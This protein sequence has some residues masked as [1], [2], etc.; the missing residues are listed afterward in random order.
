V[1][2]AGSETSMIQ[3]I[4]SLWNSLVFKIIL[5]V[6]AI[7]LIVITAWAF[8]NIHH[9]KKM[10]MDDIVR[11]C[12]QLSRAIRLGTHYAMMFNARE[13]INQII[14]NIGKLEGLEHIRI[15]DKTG[16]IKFSNIPSEV[17]VTTGIK[18]E[19]CDICH[20]VDPPLSSLPLENRKRIFVTENH[21][22]AIGMISPILNEQGCATSDCHAHPQDKTVLGALDL[23][24]SLEET[25]KKLAVYEKW[26]M[27]PAIF[28]F[29]VTST[30][31]FWV[32]L[33]L[34]IQPIQRLMDGTQKIARGEYNALNGFQQSYEIGRLADTI[35]KMGSEIGNQQMELN[36]QKD[37]YKNL[38]ELVPC[39]ISVQDRDY[40]LI[41]YNQEFSRLFDPKPGDFCYS[42]YKGR[43]EKCRFCPVEK[44]FQDG[45]SHYSEETGIN[46]DGTTSHWIV[47]TAPMKNNRGE[48]IGAMEINLDISHTRQLESRLKE[49]EKKYYAIFNNIPNPVFVLD[50]E[51]LEILDC[52]GSVTTVYGFTKEE[53][54]SRSFLA[55]FM[56][57]ER[58]DYKTEI[59]TR[60][61]MSRVRHLGKKGEVHFVNM[62]ISP[63]D[64]SEQKVLLVTTSDVTKRL[65]AESQLIQAGKMATLGEM[66]TGVAHELNQ[67][68]SVIKTA[69]SFFMK[70]IRKKEPIQDDILLTMAE[71]IDAHVD[72][73]ANIINHLR[74]FG[75]KSDIA[76]E[77]VQVNAVLRNAY[78]MFSRQLQLREIVTT[79]ELAE[80]LPLVMAEQ[81][82]LEQVF[83]NLIINAR[84]AI[85]EKWNSGAAEPGEEKKILLR[86][87]CR[88]SKVMIE[89]HDNGT[90]M[91]KDVMDKIFEPFFTTKKVGHGTGIG[92]SISYNIIKDF[93]GDI[94]VVS[95]KDKGTTFTITFPEKDAI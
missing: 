26:L 73:A 74:Q 45:Q 31:V 60:I 4:K 42:A 5:S 57:E 65:E 40:R 20:R 91:P 88:N 25:D 84:D 24:I 77:P 44:T 9:H 66:A 8:F 80:D 82:R 49:L 92:L 34:F 94:R 32:L 18:A 16:Q 67:P 10:I 1:I 41:N 17:G 11:N 22:R 52:N 56:E 70:K 21:K 81:G 72:R 38:F 85:E 29:L 30:I 39:I 2:S 95:G 58:D 12:D 93:Q 13:D 35:S 27:I 37:E 64:F 87:F 62:R 6:G 43:T 83:I 86:T 75:R 14:T 23:V 69:S 90:G 36:R 54:L 53:V 55:F 19:A 7:L 51:S 61:E 46:K 59:K 76:L 3:K 15:Y 78:D 71:E 50:Y 79:W 89:V 33:K 28:V 63:F 47:K 68:L 48:I